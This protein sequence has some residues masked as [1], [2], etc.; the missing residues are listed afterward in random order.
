MKQL[1]TQACAKI[2]LYLDVVGKRPDGYHNIES[3]MQSVSLRDEVEIA[4]DTG[5]P[6]RITC[7][8]SEVPTGKNNL[9]WKAAEAFFAAY[10]EKPDGLEIRIEKRIPMGAGLAGGSADAAA[11]LHGFNRLYGNPF[12]V[13]ELCRIGSGIGSDVPFCVLGGTAFTQQRGEDMMPIYP[14][15]RAYYVICKPNASLS[16]KEM[17]DLLDRKEYLPKL[18][19]GNLLEPLRHGTDLDAADHLYNAF[20][21]AAVSEIPEIA[22]ITRRLK[23]NGARNAQMSGSGPAVFGVFDDEKI[24]ESAYDLLRTDYPQTYLC[25]GLRAEEMK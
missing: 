16:T 3:V 23:E 22:E 7:D 19:C 6:W 1:C 9:C 8:R 11:V 4:I 10:G 12:S 15:L 5:K 20:E 13:E 14:S 25:T 24:A 17:Y 21:Q 18:G 2:N